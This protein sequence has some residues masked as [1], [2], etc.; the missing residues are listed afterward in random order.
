MFL[1]LGLQNFKTGSVEQSWRGEVI[2]NP[3]R[4]L[5]YKMRRLKA[6]LREFNQAEFGNI[7]DRVTKKRGELAA[8]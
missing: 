8:A 1:A 3:M 6:E 2:G 7:T 5:Y 4:I